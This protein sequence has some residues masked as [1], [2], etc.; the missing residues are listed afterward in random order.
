VHRDVE[1]HHG[2]CILKLFGVRCRPRV[3]RGQGQ[4]LP[5][6]LGGKE[7]PGAV[8]IHVLPEAS[9]S[10]AA[11]YGPF[12]ILSFPKRWESSIVYL[13]EMTGNRFLEQEEEV[14]AYARLFKRLMVS[15]SLDGAE[16]LNLIESHLKNYRQ[17]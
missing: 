5:T 8:N 4:R 17:G 15:E 1:P 10:H 3:E 11:L 7:Y 2:A 14:Q 9:E 16:S 6:R 13:E 12:V